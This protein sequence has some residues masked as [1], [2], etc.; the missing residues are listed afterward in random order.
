MT[1]RMCVTAS[2]VMPS[3]VKFFASD[4]TLMEQLKTLIRSLLTHYED[5]AVAFFWSL[6]HLNCYASLHLS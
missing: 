4:A 3:N 6:Q 2:G 5:P 1:N